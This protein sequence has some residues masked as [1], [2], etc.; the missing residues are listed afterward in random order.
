MLAIC[1]LPKIIFPLLLFV[2]A[3]QPIEPLTFIPH[4]GIHA[5]IDSLTPTMERYFSNHKKYII[6]IP[7]SQEKKK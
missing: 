6:N 7:K 2:F 1:Y 5:R 3:Q 4:I